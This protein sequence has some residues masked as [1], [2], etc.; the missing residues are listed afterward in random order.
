[1]KTARQTESQQNAVPPERLIFWKRD[2]P[3]I[4]GVSSRTIDR[5]IS[6]GEFPAPDVSLHGRPVW[7]RETLLKWMGA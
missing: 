2:L 1:M 3:V 4:C 7:R 6:S 5:W